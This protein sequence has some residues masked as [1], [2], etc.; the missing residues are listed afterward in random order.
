MTVIRTLAAR[1]I[2]DSRQTPTIEVELATD[3]V[4][5]RAS[6]PSGAS[7]GSREALELRDGDLARFNGKGVLHAITG[8]QETISPQILNRELDQTALDK[9]LLELDGT[10]HKSHLGANATLAVSIAFA[11]AAALEQGMPLYQH[12]SA[13]SGQHPRLPTPMCNIL[14]GGKHTTSGIDIQ[15]CMLTPVGL[16]GVQEQVAAMQKCIETLGR[17]LTKGGFETN[18]GDEGGFAPSL[19]SNEQAFELLAETI[20]QSG[21]NFDVIKI[22]I[23]AAATSF[24]KDGS[25]TL[26]TDQKLTHKT[27]EELLSWYIQLINTYPILSVEDPFHEDD[28]ESF[29]ALVAVLGRE[30]PVFVVGDDLLVTNPTLI[31]K[32]AERGA[33]KGAI[34]K[35]NQ[36]GTVSEALE[37]AREARA[38]S[39]QVCASHRSG[40]TL[41]T[42]IADFAVG[43][44]ADFIKAG[45]P[46]KPERT[47]KYDRLIEIESTL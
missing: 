40:E 9:T 8:I 20:V 33:A 14:N 5:V 24:Y 13:I 43:V 12:I 36:I 41:D 29:A 1:E 31:K 25:Y 17:L 19:P 21:F 23:D 6:V 22:S 35:P 32:A 7:V 47:A 15:E 11:R 45:A 27:K 3:S 2:L 44:G 10:P 39:M 46:T 28:W 37:A 34:I 26:H 4:N 16:R 38:S 30:S 42:F 18:L